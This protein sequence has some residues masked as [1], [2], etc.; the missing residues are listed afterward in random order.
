M[1]NVLGALLFVIGT[2]LASAGPLTLSMRVEPPEVEAGA[3]PVFVVTFTNTTNDAIRIL[4]FSA[5]GDLQGAYLPVEIRQGSRKVDLPRA[6]SDP[7]PLSDDAYRFIGP[8][9]SEVVRLRSIPIAVHQLKP[10]DYTA[11]VQYLEPFRAAGSEVVDANAS[12]VVRK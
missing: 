9:Q 8:H 5:R 11:I 6:I 4:N 1:A 7:R 3:W 12:L 10:G 2:T